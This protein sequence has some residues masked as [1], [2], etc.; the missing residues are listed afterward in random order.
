MSCC[1]FWPL[2]CVI[3]IDSIRYL[4][5]MCLWP[6]PRLLVTFFLRV[7]YDP[8]MP[9]LT[10]NALPG[11]ALLRFGSSWVALRAYSSLAALPVRRFS[12]CNLIRTLDHVR[13]AIAELIDSRCGRAAPYIETSLVTDEDLNSSH[14]RIESSRSRLFIVHL[15]RSFLGAS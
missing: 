4:P 12:S 7:I 8:V 2:Y 13:L 1:C 5:A 14:A 10:T 15:P 6:V 9:S 3:L 11:L